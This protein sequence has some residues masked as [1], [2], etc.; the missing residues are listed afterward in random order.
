MQVGIKA[1]PPMHQP[2]V[3]PVA[4]SSQFAPAPSQYQQPKSKYDDYGKL[5]NAGGG[6]KYGGGA[7][8]SKYGGGMSDS[9]YGGTTAVHTHPPQSRFSNSLIS[10]A[11]FFSR[12]RRRVASCRSFSPTQGTPRYQRASPFFHLLRAL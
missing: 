4:P 7:S 2:V 8:D 5:S 12:Y 1:P 9:K 11:I 10:P 3:Q 6:S